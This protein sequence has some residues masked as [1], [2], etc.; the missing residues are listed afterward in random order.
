MV[1]NKITVTVVY[2]LTLVVG[3]KPIGALT[4]GVVLPESISLVDEALEIY[5]LIIN[6][7][8]ELFVDIPEGKY[9]ESLK[10]GEE[11]VKGSVVDGKFTVA[12]VADLNHTIS[13]KP[14]L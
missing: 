8:V 14:C 12:V 10:V 13:F 4:T 9:I 2:D 5:Y 6:S 1:D 7:E 11:K 3:Y